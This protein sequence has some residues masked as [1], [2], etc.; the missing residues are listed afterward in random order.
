MKHNEKKNIPERVHHFWYTKPQVKPG[1]VREMTNRVL[2]SDHFWG[3]AGKHTTW[4][5]YYGCSVNQSLHLSILVD[6]PGSL[7]NFLAL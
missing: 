2:H 4:Y 1:V 7:Y 3:V 5:R 6:I